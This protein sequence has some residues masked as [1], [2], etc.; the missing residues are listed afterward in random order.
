MYEPEVNNR[1]ES[2]DTLPS[3]V[4]KRFAELQFQVNARTVLPWGE[5]CTECAWPTCYTTCEL[6]DP[7][8]DGNCRLFKDGMVRVDIDD[9]IRPYLLKLHFKRWGKL[10]AI[11]NLAMHGTKE[12][13]R[14][15]NKNMLIGALA[16]SVPL[17][18]PLKSRVLGKVA[19]L[20]RCAAETAPVAA[21]FPHC[22]L[23][24]CY[25][26]NSQ[27]I[28]LT[29]TIRPR[30]QEPTRAYRRV[31]HVG[32]G[33]LC[34]RVPLEE[35]RRE[36]DLS[37]PFDIEIVPSEVESAVLYFG[38]MD[39]VWLNVAPLG[40]ESLPSV[41]QW[42]CIVWD[43][44]NTLWDGTLIEDGPEGIRLR[45]EVVALIKETDR[46]G[47]LHSI[48]SKNN[49]ADA[50]NVLQRWGLA[51]YFLHPQ[52]GW[53]PKSQSIAR[54]AKLLN[55]GVDTLAF[56]DDQQFERE[57]VRARHAQVAVV[58]A[59]DVRSISSR[60]EC[61]VLVTEE[62]QRRRF[63]YRQ[64]EEREHALE[65]FQGD[66]AKFLRECQLE[67]LLTQLTSENLERV[68]ELAQRTNQM[69]FSGSRYPRA[70]LQEIQQSGLHS[71]YVMHCTDR[72]G[73]YGIVGFALVDTREP[74]LLDL[75]FSCRIQGK[76]VEHGFLGYVLDNFSQPHRRDF[77]AN[78]RK[79]EKNAA[80]GKVFE[81]I[82]FEVAGEQEEVLSLIFRKDRAVPQ[83]KIIR[84][85]ERTGT[86]E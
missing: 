31:I 86:G 36:V 16:R 22:F 35:I 1:F 70:K 26:P 24:E 47:I 46:R 6:Y 84:I 76:R 25:N 48:A 7:R 34:E 39:F 51:E 18:L 56:V 11:G 61:L 37:Q 40:A 29:L 67:L 59:S 10:W 9:D 85:V 53:H 63:M 19:Y 52:I 13:V 81:E 69:N 66:Y 38:L 73:S 62:S 50:M 12:V 28:D 3:A 2:I 44:D 79:T 8:M 42:K 68:Y 82:G 23:L 27:S 83:E 43:L 45:D 60:Q 64:E 21:E 20:R 5:H 72:F 17:P 58:D 74:R 30:Q 77:F 80:A 55:I 32:S 78:F 57:E 49:P 14:I 4:V 54:I 75:M 15:E 33:F 65:S 71:T 41:K